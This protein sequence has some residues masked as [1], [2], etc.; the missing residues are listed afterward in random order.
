[1]D[2]AVLSNVGRW[3]LRPNSADVR[4]AS[5]EVQAGDVSNQWAPGSGV[6]LDPEGQALL[7]VSCGYRAFDR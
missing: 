1:M 3:F 2:K 7:C 4:I 6:T 5:L